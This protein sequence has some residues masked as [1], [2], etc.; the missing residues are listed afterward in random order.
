MCHN[1]TGNEY[2]EIQYGNKR[3]TENTKNM[4]GLK[5]A[6]VK[7]VNCT[8]GRKKAPPTPPMRTVSIHK[9]QQTRGEK[10]KGNQNEVNVKSSDG[11]V[12]KTKENIGNKIEI[13]KQKNTVQNSSE[14]KNTHTS[15][16]AEFECA[17]QQFQIEHEKLN[18]I[19]GKVNDVKQAEEKG[20]VKVNLKDRELANKFGKEIVK[21]ADSDPIKGNTKD[22]SIDG[23]GS[24]KKEGVP[25]KV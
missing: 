12:S 25:V 2:E 19:K 11:R 10:V 9:I 1:H 14:N 3:N 5:S 7:M 13:I 6:F 4:G 20:G 21:N 22:V 23:K 18:K 24:L 17:L 16:L 15:K 8:V